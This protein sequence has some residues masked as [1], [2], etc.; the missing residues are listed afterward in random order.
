M[1][2]Y[3]NSGALFHQ[4][5]KKNPKAPDYSG[6]IIL[7]L[8]DFIEEPDGTIKVRLAGWKKQSKSGSTFLS[9]SGSA[10]LQKTDEPK[11][12]FNN[13]GGFEQMD[14]DIPF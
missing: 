5:V 12:E 9:L 2:E 10:P 13:G 4:A 14:E 6:E 11:R 3:K 7:T 1:A 8:R